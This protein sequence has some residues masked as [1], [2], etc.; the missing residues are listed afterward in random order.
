M[1]AQPT[2]IRQIVSTT[3]LT[4]AESPLQRQICYGSRSCWST[5]APV[6]KL[7]GRCDG[8]A[9]MSWLTSAIFVTPYSN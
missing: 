9:A 8:S 7:C 6:M 5:A 2:E 3:C 4:A 1:T